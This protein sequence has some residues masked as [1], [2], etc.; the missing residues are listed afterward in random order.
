MNWIKKLSDFI[1]K[2][3]PFP[4]DMGKPVRYPVR[5]PKKK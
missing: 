5:R 1:E 4:R 2:Y 3:G